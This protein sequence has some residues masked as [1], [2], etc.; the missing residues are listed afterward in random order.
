[1]SQNNIFGQILQAI[2]PQ[3]NIRDYQHAARTFV[4]GLY[5]L[6]PKYQSL[7]HVYMDINTDISGIQQVAQIETG[8]MAKHVN[9]P[10]FTV[11]TKTYN[12][13]NRKTVQQE[14]VSYDPVN[15][16]FHDDSSDVVRS[17]WKDYFTYYYRDSDYGS[18]GGNMDRY[19]D[20]SKYKTR[21]QQNW[22]YT[23]RTSN[24]A[25]LPYLNSIRIYSLHQ[26]RFSSYTLIRPVISTFQHGTHTTGEYAPM[27]HT[28]TVNY[29]AVLYDTGPVSDG[30]VLG[31]DGIHYD[32]TPSPLRNL[33]ALVGGVESIFNN[34]ENGDLGSAVQNSF[35][36]YNVATGSNSQLLQT[37][38]LNIL[39]IGQ[40]ILQGQ[41]PLSTV[42]APT[43]ATVNQGLSG[44]LTAQPGLGSVTNALN[45]NGQN[46]NLPSSNQG[47]AGL[48]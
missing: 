9:L 26:K 11:A 38:N 25:N 20:N 43:S 13:Y 44:S 12:A 17:F 7:F 15:I 28:M 45:I 27:E 10:K 47:I 41:N 24:S 4:D 19:K 29:E 32:H 16:T 35:N 30:T 5:R 22:G 14:K 2:A 34:I 40:T 31:F 42:F 36:V 8:M 6:S 37:P 33:G 39:G 23:P 1:M 18:P 48:F 46:N 3:E 21:Q